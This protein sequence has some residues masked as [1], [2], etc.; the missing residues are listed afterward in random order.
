MR[1]LIWLA[2]AVLAGCSN[3]PSAVPS[4]GFVHVLP[5]SGQPTLMCDGRPLALD[6]DHNEIVL[7]GDCR[8]VRITG[9]HNDVSIDVAPGGEV[10]ITGLHDDVF[11][12]QSRPGPRPVLEDHGTPGTNTFHARTQAP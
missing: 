11:W 2:S 3:P 9:E 10:E 4:D 1:K 8:R 12:W 6:G 7:T 5:V